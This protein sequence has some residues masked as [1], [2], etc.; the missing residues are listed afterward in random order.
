MQRLPRGQARAVANNPKCL[1]CEP[2]YVCT[3]A[4]TARFPS[5]D[6]PS[7]KGYICPAGYYCPAGSSEEL[8]CPVGHYNAETGASNVTACTPCSSGAYQDNE[9]SVGCKTCSSSSESTGLA[10]TECQCA[11]LYRAFQPTDGYC[12][13]QP[14]YEWYDESFTKQSGDGDVDCQPVVYPRC[15]TS[16]VRDQSGKCVEE[17][18]CSSQCGAA[19]GTFVPTSCGCECNS[20]DVHDDVCDADFPDAAPYIPTTAAGE[21]SVCDSTG[22]CTTVATSDIDGFHGSVSC[23]SGDCATHSMDVTSGSFAGVYGLAA[24]VETQARRMR[25]RKLLEDSSTSSSSSISNPV[26]CIDA[27]DSVFFDVDSTN[28]PTYMKDSLLNTNDDFDYGEFRDL[29]SAAASTTVVSSFGFTFHSP[30]IYVFGSS[31]SDAFTL[32]AVMEDGNECA[33]D[34]QATFVPMSEKN[35]KLM[36][37]KLDSDNIITDPDWWIIGGLLGGLLVLIT[38]LIAFIHKFRKEEW[39]TKGYHAPEYRERTR[40]SNLASLAA[41]ESAV[42]KKAAPKGSVTKGSAVVAPGDGLGDPLGDP[43]AAAEEGKLDDDI[44]E[45]EFVI[46]EGDPGT[47]QLLKHLQRHHDVVEQKFLGQ[48]DMISNLKE[49]LQGEADDLR[50]ILNSMMLQK[51]GDEGASDLDERNAL[52]ALKQDMGARRVHDHAI[53]QVEKAVMDQVN[54][55]QELI[56]RGPDNVGQMIIAEVAKEGYI[57]NPAPEASP[58]LA[59]IVDELEALRT[60]VETKLL[61]NLEK[62]SRRLNISRSLW[63]NANASKTMDAELV[64]SVASVDDSTSTADNTTQRF[65]SLFKAFVARLPNFSKELKHQES[66]LL[67]ELSIAHETRNYP[68]KAEAKVKSRPKLV[69]LLEQLRDA[70]LSVAGKSV[71]AKETLVGEREAAEAEREKLE[72][73]VNGMP[74]RR[75][76][77]RPQLPSRRL[78]PAMRT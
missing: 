25:R 74:K 73:R 23:I 33:T 40:H 68:A 49:A 24:A 75:P 17:G 47:D 46:D 39:S 53:Q 16:Q 64:E 18:D 50:R 58:I 22:N 78:A 70:L 38:G 51:G 77:L 2:G 12:I 20:R 54:R 42:K 48:T 21:H 15:G 11:G 43:E 3:G 62:E 52:V 19:G 57:D 45:G 31:S 63:E 61:P 13:C 65:A 72:E 5:E 71:E 30:G 36:N 4:T 55:L 27:G 56:Q 32:V 37:A 59:E 44:A 7:D 34:D 35:M 76:R 6:S 60:L 9:G 69:A 14:G 8:P 28:Y 29:A 41:K 1:E 66:R 10:N 67:Q 26:V